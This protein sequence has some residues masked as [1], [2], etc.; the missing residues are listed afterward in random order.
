VNESLVTFIEPS[1]LSRWPTFIGGRLES[2]LEALWR[3]AD[4]RRRVASFSQH[5]AFFFGGSLAPF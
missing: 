2:E 5:P 1:A 4:C 3:H